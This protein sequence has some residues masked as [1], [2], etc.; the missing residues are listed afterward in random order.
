MF[1][2]VTKGVWLLVRPDTVIEVLNQ[3][4]KLA[5]SGRPGPVFV[6]VPFDIQQAQVE[7]EV[8][9]P[10]RRAITSRAS[11]RQRDHATRRSS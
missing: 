10:S 3:A 6:Q 11:A 4:Y 9:A 8:E 7:G 2:P 5:A 1:R